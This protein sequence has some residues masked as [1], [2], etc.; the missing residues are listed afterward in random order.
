MS[1]QIDDGIGR[2]QRVAGELRPPP[3]DQL[4]LVAALEWQAEEFSERSGVSCQVTAPGGDFDLD[5]ERSTAL[6]RI[7]QEA[8]TN[9]HRHAGAA[10]VRGTCPR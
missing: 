2:V 4:G 10:S 1:A 8:L 3:L 9:V 5:E 6:F 7:F